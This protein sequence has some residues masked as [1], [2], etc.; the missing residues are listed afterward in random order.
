MLETTFALV[1]VFTWFYQRRANC[2]A[3]G[4]GTS[5]NTA[6]QSQTAVSAYLKSKQILPFGFARKNRQLYLRISPQSGHMFPHHLQDGLCMVTVNIRRLRGFWSHA[7]LIESGIEPLFSWSMNET[8]LMRCIQDHWII[9]KEISNNACTKIAC[10]CT[11]TSRL[12]VCVVIVFWK[13][14][15]VKDKT[16]Q[17]AIFW[18][19]Q[20]LFWQIG[21]IFTDLKLWIA[22]ASH[23]FRRVK[24]PI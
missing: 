23:N 9:E 24:I 3:A 15:H 14:K 5:H 18:N 8:F 10:Q 7:H 13:S 19:S 4:I 17:S 6:L 21:I 16:C 12:T 2:R 22:L 20:P 1:T 11:F